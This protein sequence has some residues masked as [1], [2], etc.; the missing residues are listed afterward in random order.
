MRITSR[1]LTTMIVLAVAGTVA[2]QTWQQFHGGTGHAGTWDGYVNP[3]L[4]APAWTFDPA[5]YGISVD[6]FVR[7][8]Q[9]AVGVGE[10][11]VFVYGND[12]GGG[13]QGK[14]V[15]INAVTGNLV[16]TMNVASQASW[17]SVSSPVYS[18]GYV[19]WAGSDGGFPTTTGYVYKINALN[20][21]TAA[22][23]GGW[24]ATFSGDGFINAAPVVADGRVFVV[25]YTWIGGTK[26]YA[27]SDTDG[28]VL[29]VNNTLGGT[30]GGAPAYDAAR[31]LLYQTGMPDGQ[32]RLCA[33]SASAGTL[34][35]S[36]PFTLTNADYQIAVTYANN[37]IYVQDFA[38]FGDDGTLY[39]AD[40][41]NTVM[42]GNLLWAKP[43]R[44]SANT[45]PAVDPSGNVY[46]GGDLNS[47]PWPGKE[48]GRTRAYDAAGNELWTVENAGGIYGSPAW[49]G[50][51]VFAGDQAA[52]LLY[53]LDAANGDVLAILAGSG[54]VAFGVRH[55][56]TIGANGVLYA[57][58]T[59]A[60]YACAGMFAVLPAINDFTKEPKVYAQGL[61]QDGPKLKAEVAYYDNDV[62][63]AYF[64]KSKR[65]YDEVWA[66][67]YANNL[68]LS[69]FRQ[70]PPSAFAV[71]TMVPVPGGW[72]E[73]DGYCWGSKKPR[74]ELLQQ[75]ENGRE[76]RYRCK[77]E[78]A[79]MLPESGRSMLNCL[80]PDR[81][82]NGT[83]LLRLS[84]G[85]TR[86]QVLI[87]GIRV[88]NEP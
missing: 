80:L 53:L 10:G 19:Y 26:H 39:V 52:N 7:D 63:V 50:G 2:A 57:Y 41:A 86:L 85:H 20:G 15:A 84:F 33:L 47:V 13:D 8:S 79:T 17:D 6:D 83:Y 78:S 64:K 37:R 42:P 25:T 70:L 27:L 23:H 35:W 4:T 43:T 24:V 72:L 66:D 38:F 29:W 62:I 12:A 32:L 48:A 81:L 60:N 82:A 3:V 14:I 31:G 34:A 28:S 51:I 77:V 61:G 5:D 30:G 75:L 9:P 87:P 44:G 46:V 65:R 18:N 76:K 16:W 36:S 74:V 68:W 45:A 11:L 58:T 73:V 56:Y 59:G 55:F 22:V 69:R 40:A 1:L 21:S 67:I 54:P 88:S 71:S 49:A